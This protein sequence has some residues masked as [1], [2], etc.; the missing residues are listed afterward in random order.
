MPVNAALNSTVNFTCEANNVT[1]IHLLVNEKTIAELSGFSNFSYT[2]F[3][4]NETIKVFS[5]SFLA[6]VKYNNTNISCVGEPGRIN[7]TNALL[8]I[9]GTL[10]N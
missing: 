2:L 10:I 4:I 9:Q 8:M 3:T 7:S 5:V 6:E 1:F